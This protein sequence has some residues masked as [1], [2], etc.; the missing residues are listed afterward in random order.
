MSL[1]VLE[2]MQ[3][4]QEV[5]HIEEERIQVLNN[6]EELEQKIKDLENQMEES[7]REVVS[8]VQ[9]T[10]TTED[11]QGS[12]QKSKGMLSTQCCCFLQMEVECA[13]LEGEHESEMGQ[14]QR[15]KELLDQLKDKLH[16][17]EKTSHTE[18]SQVKCTV[19]K[20]DKTWIH[21]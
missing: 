3:L 1:Q 15:E 8:T 21:F 14:L 11:D 4:K 16:S 10:N 18:K 20:N 9:H 12:H 2:S 6:I 5:T 19:V 7:V 17:V 13:L